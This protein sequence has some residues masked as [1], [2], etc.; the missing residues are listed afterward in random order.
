MRLTK[1]KTRT[2]PIAMSSV[3][4]MYILLPYETGEGPH[5]R[6]GLAGWAPI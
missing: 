2:R 6:R 3:S 1:V 5:A 4:N